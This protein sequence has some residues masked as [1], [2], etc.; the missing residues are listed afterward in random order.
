MIHSLEKQGLIAVPVAK[1]DDVRCFIRDDD[2]ISSDAWPPEDPRFF[3][4]TCMKDE[5]PF[6]LEW[7][8]WH[9]AIGIQ[10]IVVFTND[11]SD[12]TD[13]IL[14]RL[15]A[16]GHLRHLPNP[17]VLTSSTYYQP[18]ALAYTPHLSE[19][20]RADFFISIDVDEFINIRVGQGHMADLLGAVG[21]FDA[22]SMAELNH[23]SNNHLHF[24]PGLVTEQFPRHQGE[25]PGA[26]KALRGVKTITRISDKL[27]KPRN[28]RPDFKD[29]APPPIWRDGSGGRID[30]LAA[31]PSLNGIDVRGRYDL[32]VLDHFPLRSLDSYLI[33]MLRGDVVVK[34]HRVSRRYWRL[35]NRNEKLSSDFTRQ[36][37]AFQT[38]LQRL[39]DDRQLSDLHEKACEVHRERAEQL[40]EVPEF[41]ERRQWILENAW[42]VEE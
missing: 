16:M 21:P 32:V 17:A 24:Q 34:S 2:V 19:W 6:I 31:D 9:K 15:E 38:F 42:D 35:R 25:N 12:G 28:H 4:S 20:Q 37:K 13:L 3:I 40:R 10:D 26:R 36:K 27:D 22:L 11:C 7:V 23:G 18:A 33:K 29:D 30:T 5:G 8:A 41:K 14:D 39:H 1:P